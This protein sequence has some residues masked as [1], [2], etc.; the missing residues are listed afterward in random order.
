MIEGAFKYVRQAVMEEYLE[1]FV[2]EW[3]GEK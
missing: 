1:E 3:E 2:L